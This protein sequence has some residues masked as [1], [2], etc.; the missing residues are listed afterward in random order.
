[1]SLLF[2]SNA[3]GNTDVSVEWDRGDGTHVHIVGGKNMVSGE[4]LQF[5]D[6]AVVLEPGDAMH[7]TASGNTS[8]HIDAL[9]TVE[10]IFKPVG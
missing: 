7:V 8:P 9:C 6:G 3:N 1:M 5:S 4:Y 10:E 2:L